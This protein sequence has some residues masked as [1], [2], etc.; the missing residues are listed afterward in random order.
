MSIFFI[1]SELW[2]LYVQSGGYFV[3]KEREVCGL[4]RYTAFL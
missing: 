1:V 3:A 2:S 4:H